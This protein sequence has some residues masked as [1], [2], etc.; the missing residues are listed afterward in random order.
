[1]KKRPRTLTSFYSPALTPV[2]P[3]VQPN[4]NLIESTVE[5]G[6]SAAQGIATEPTVETVQ[7]GGNSSQAQEISTQAIPTEQVFDIVAD[8]G[9]RKL[10]DEYDVNI[11]DAVRREYLLRG[12]CQPIGHTYP[13]KKIGDRMRSFH[14]SWF[15]NHNW[16]EYSVV[17]DAAFCFYCYLFKHQRHENFGVDTFTNKGFT[18]WKKA[19]TCF[20]EHV[21]KVDSLHNKARKHC[22]DFRNQR[23]SVGHAMTSGSKKHE[24]EYLDRIT[25]ML[26]IVRFLLS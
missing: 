12:P 5:T 14:D 4:V 25:I 21:G 8:P 13:K 9:L 10:I 26:G 17:K 3:I 23:Q 20:V 22:E 11:R 18:N 7:H 24:E 15:K 2:T 6:V 1:M 19:T 16:F